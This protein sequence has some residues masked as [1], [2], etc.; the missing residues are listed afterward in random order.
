M[1]VLPS[2]ALPAGQLGVG[3]GVSITDMPG[4]SLGALCIFFFH[5]RIMC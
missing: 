4:F 1:R 5:F 3:G 2:A